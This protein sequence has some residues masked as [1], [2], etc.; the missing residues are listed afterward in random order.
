[1]VDKGGAQ[2]LYSCIKVTIW[3]FR[4]KNS[5]AFWIHHSMLVSPTHFDLNKRIIPNHSNSQGGGLSLPA[6]DKVPIK[7]SAIHPSILWK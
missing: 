7:A 1:M 3:Y 4:P 6:K 2:S 5:L